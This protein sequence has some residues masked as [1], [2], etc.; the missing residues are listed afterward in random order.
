MKS[1]TFILILFSTVANGQWYIGG[2]AAAAFSKY[3]SKT[4]WTE[5]AN[6]GYAAGLTAFRQIKSNLGMNIELEYIQKGYYHKV[7]NTITDR[8]NTNYLEIPVMIDY[9]FP[10]PSVK[11]FKVHITLGA[12]G[13]YWLSGKYK[14][15]GFDVQTEDFNFEKNS[16]SHFDFGPSA[17]ARIEYILMN[18]S[19]SLDIRFEKGLV[20]LEKRTNDNTSN[21]NQ[22]MIIGISYMKVMGIL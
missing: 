19:F 20:D 8:L 10:I 15:Q 5:V 3:K 16:A 7:C 4:Q 21:T 17:G 22:S 13:A 1:L 18:G 11:N 6:G 2:K 12:Y 9:S 14:T